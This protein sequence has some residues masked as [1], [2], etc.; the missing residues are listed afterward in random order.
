MSEDR[1]LGKESQ[2]HLE[3]PGAAVTREFRLLRELRSWLRDIFFAALTAILIVAFVVQPVRVEGTS[4]LPQLSDGERIFVNKFTYRLSGIERGDIVV[5]WYPKNPSE[6]LIKRVIGLPGETIEIFSGVV[7][8]DGHR[9]DEPY[10]VPR[11]RD[12]TS[13]ARVRVPEKSYFVLGDRRDSSND[14]RNWG[15]VPGGNIFG[16]AFLRYWPISEFGLI[17]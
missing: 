11:Y 6:S 2:E 9:L 3:D 16:K 15:V 12:F 5:F 14:S 17:N 4:M 10:V 8:V 13:L 7:R 1:V